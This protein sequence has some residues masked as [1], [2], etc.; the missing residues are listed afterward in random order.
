MHRNFLASL[1]A[2][3]LT[4]KQTAT[5]WLIGAN[6]GVSQI[7]IAN[8]LDMD[9]ATM[10]A[11]IDRLDERGYVLRRRSQTD[12]RRQELYLTPR[13]QAMLTEVKARIAE[14][15]RWIKRAFSEDEVRRLAEALRRL[16]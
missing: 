5:L 6:S 9:R 8:E 16:Y 14:H 1:A 12:R 3:D 2:V 10:M 11:I 7:Q 15:E 13:G 4:Q